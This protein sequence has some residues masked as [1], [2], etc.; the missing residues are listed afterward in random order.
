MQQK[1]TQEADFRQERD[2]GQKIGATFEFIGA[3][4]RPLGKCLAY[5]VL[6]AALLTGLATGLFQNEV[7]GG[8]DGFSTGRAQPRTLDFMGSSSYLLSLLTSLISYILLGT[9]VYGYLRLRL[10][11]PATEV[12]TPRQVGQYVARYSL[13]FLLSS[14]VGGLVVG[15]GFMLLVIPGI[16]LAVALSLLW[17]VQIL[18]D[19]SLGHSFRRSLNLVRDHWWATLGLVLVVSMII[20]IMGIAFQIPQYLAI[21]GKAFHWSFL[22]SDFVMIIG[23]ILMAIGHTL[24][25]TVLMLAL[26]FQYFNLVEKKDGLGLRSMIDS[27]GS[28]TAPTVSNT[29]LRP[30]DEGEY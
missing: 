25:Y 19:A 7:F 9:T 24:L 18:E 12:I 15:L 6:P 22:S 13:P 20:S 21:F 30:D 3:H 4:W 27:L 23:G 16:Y 5:Y 10:E 1:F 2:F 29:S 11:T 17:V 28:T 26:A 14:L 8:M